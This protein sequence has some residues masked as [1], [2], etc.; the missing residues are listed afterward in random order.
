MNVSVPVELVVRYDEALA[1]IKAAKTQDE[2]EKAWRQLDVAA[3][4][5]SQTAL[6][7]WSLTVR[8]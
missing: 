3:Y 2:C 5:I 6:S 8:G 1:G 7:N 4:A